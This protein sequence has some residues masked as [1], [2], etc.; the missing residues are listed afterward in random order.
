MK[1]FSM[2]VIGTLNT[3]TVPGRVASDL[4]DAI[5]KHML[6]WLEESGIPIHA[7]KTNGSTLLEKAGFYLSSPTG[8]EAAIKRSLQIGLLFT[9]T[10]GLYHMGR[11]RMEPEDVTALSKAWGGVNLKE[12]YPKMD[13][14]TAEAIKEDNN[15]VTLC[16]TH[17]KELQKQVAPNG[18]IKVGLGPDDSREWVWALKTKTKGVYKI[19]NVPMFVYGY[20]LGDHIRVKKTADG[21]FIAGKTVEH[22][23]NTTFGVLIET[24]D[25]IKN[26]VLGFL[27]GQGCDIEG[28]GHN[29]WGVN[30][31]KGD[32]KGNGAT[33]IYLWLLHK[34]NRVK[35]SCLSHE[36]N[37]EAFDRMM[38]EF[39]EREGFLAEFESRFPKPQPI[40]A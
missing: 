26:A 10:H 16:E 36:V 34:T 14:S 19:D 23:G 38:E 39:P 40:A 33:E 9:L 5:P 7:E 15:I 25:E 11:T 18:S 22:S 28:A 21:G 17:S 13:A 20:S 2:Y 6:P 1:H 30:V 35:V 4:L 29:Y 3:S 31:P 12:L 27:K 32:P 8:D 24:G 37:L